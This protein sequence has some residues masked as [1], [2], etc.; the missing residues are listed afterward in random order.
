MS[1]E[2]WGRMFQAEET[3]NKASCASCVQGTA[4]K[5]VIKLQSPKK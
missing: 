1:R 2:T 4:R 3:A 5:G